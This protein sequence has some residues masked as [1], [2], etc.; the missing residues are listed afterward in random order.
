MIQ[1][2]HLV[3]TYG[4]A[5]VLQSISFTVDHQELPDVFLKAASTGRNDSQLSA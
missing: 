5:P 1:L 2:E 3:K 4:E